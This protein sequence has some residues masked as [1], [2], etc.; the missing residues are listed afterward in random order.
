[1]SWNLKPYQI[2]RS[3]H[4]ISLWDILKVDYKQFLSLLS[5]KCGHR[6]HYKQTNTRTQLFVE[7]FI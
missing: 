4:T 1:M 5:S 6:R 3:I 2:L 7:V